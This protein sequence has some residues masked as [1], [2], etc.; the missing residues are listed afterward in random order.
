MANKIRR[1]ALYLRVSTDQQT[2]EN[3]RRELTGAAE[4]HGWQVVAEYADNGI[5]GAKGREARPGLDQLLKDATRGRVDVV[6]AWSVD[7]LGRSLQDLLGTLG[8]LHAAK[9]NLFLHRQAVDTRAGR[10]CL[11]P[12]ARR[13]R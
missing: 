3:Q 2:I 4:H 7:R 5:S 13:V 6:M 10:T 1:A 8:E 12:D 11:V 9:V